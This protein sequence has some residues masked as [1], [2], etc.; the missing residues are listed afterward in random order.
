VT[1]DQAGSLALIFLG[2]MVLTVFWPSAYFAAWRETL[3]R[4]LMI[5]ACICGCVWSILPASGCA[6]PEKK[7]VPTELLEPQIPPKPSFCP[8]GWK[9]APELE[10][11]CLPDTVG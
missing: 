9:H 11:G 1:S 3:A 10:Y 7:R 2:L 5:A 4:W 8:Q 6:G